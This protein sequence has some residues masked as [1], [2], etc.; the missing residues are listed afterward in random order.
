MDQNGDVNNVK[1]DRNEISIKSSF[2]SYDV[3]PSIQQS[4]HMVVWIYFCKFGD[5]LK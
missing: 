1:H 4:D 2:F 3:N 5:I